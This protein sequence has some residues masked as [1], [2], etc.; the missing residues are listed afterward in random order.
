MFLLAKFI[1]AMEPHHALLKVFFFSQ[2][3]MLIISGW[4]F[5]TFFSIQ[6]GRII[7]TIL[8]N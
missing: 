4:W 1:I 3:I 7:P 5:G 6:L 2:F 8:P